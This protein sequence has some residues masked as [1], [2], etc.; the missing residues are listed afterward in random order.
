M[1][2]EDSTRQGAANP[3]PEHLD[4][5]CPDLMLG[6]RVRHQ[7]VEGVRK[8]A[9]ARFPYEPGSG[10]HGVFLHTVMHDL[11]PLLYHVFAVLPG[12]RGIN[13]VSPGIKGRQQLLPFHSSGAGGQP[14][15]LSLLLPRTVAPS[16]KARGLQLSEMLVQGQSKISARFRLRCSLKPSTDSIES[17]LIFMPLAQQ[18]CHSVFKV[19]LCMM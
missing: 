9:V 19:V 18:Q 7:V 15:A 4:G 14:D 8:R 11:Q 3:V 6:V 17:L 16:P 12:A 2:A 5:L 13:L 1:P 10:Q